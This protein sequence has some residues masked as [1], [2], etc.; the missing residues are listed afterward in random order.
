MQRSEGE[1]GRVDERGIRPPDAYV[2]RRGSGPDGVIVVE[3]EGELDRGAA[4]ALERHF[5]AAGAERPRAIVFDMAAVE[6]VDSSALRVVLG[7][8]E[9]LAADGVQF[10]LAGVAPQVRRLFEL[11]GTDGLLPMAPTLD[12][13]LA[14]MDGA[15]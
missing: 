3:V 14:R 15:G 10:V 6:F 1:R 13:A 12:E 7:V 11:T 4:P 9:A 8:R 2:M 5:R